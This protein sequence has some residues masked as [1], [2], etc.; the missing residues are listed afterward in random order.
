MPASLEEAKERLAEHEARARA[1]AQQPVRPRPGRPQRPQTRRRISAR[2]A[3]RHR[4][5]AL[6]DPNITPVRR[7]RLEFQGDGLTQSALADRAQVALRTIQHIEAGSPP[8]P[9]TARRIAR[10]LDVDAAT[11]A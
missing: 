10:A 8:S 7:A 1:A 11:L 4:A 3:A 5:E 6:A 9:A 2:L